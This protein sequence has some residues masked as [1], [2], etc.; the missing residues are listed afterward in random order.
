LLTPR[1][2]KTTVVAAVTHVVH[3]VTLAQVLI[4]Q[5][6]TAQPYALHAASLALPMVVTSP[7]KQTLLLPQVLAQATH[8]KL[9]LSVLLVKQPRLPLHQQRLTVKEN[10]YVAT[11]SPEIPQRAKRP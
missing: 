6:V 9:P 8:R 5:Q 4:V 2:Q 7:Q 10:N 1:V 3:V 11:R